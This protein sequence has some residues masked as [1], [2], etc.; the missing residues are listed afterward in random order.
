MRELE[1]LDKALQSMC[2]ELTN[3][4]AKLTDIYK[5]MAKEKRKLQKAE[6]ESK[7]DITARLKN[8]EDESSARLEATTANKEA[9]RAQIN[10]IKET[11]NKVLKKDSTLGEKLKAL[12]K[13]QGITIISV[14]TA[15]GHHH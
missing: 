5:Y 13:K 15:I 9:L 7:R 14:L 2:G 1:G 6:D 4:L 8:L 10:R 12:S 11:I 3:N